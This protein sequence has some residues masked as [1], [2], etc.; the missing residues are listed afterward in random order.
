MRVG[1]LATAGAHRTALAKRALRIAVLFSLKP[2]CLSMAPPISASGMRLLYSAT[3]DRAPPPSA[4]LS[5]A[6]GVDALV[7]SPQARHS[8]LGRNRMMQTAGP[9]PP[10]STTALP[11]LRTPLARR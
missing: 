7:T 2:W 5:T 8:T 10:I 4:V 11:R 1:I 6:T 9:A 3:M